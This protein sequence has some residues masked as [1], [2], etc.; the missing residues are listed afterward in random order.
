MAESKPDEPEIARPPTDA[1]VTRG[2][3][4]KTRAVPPPLPPTGPR[5][6]R[7]VKAVAPAEGA[8]APSLYSQVGRRSS[9]G[10]FTIGPC[11]FPFGRKRWSG[12]LLCLIMRA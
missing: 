12:R 4:L 9:P 2:A 5:S 1:G 10:E 7:A 6:S 11:S 3:P 8:E